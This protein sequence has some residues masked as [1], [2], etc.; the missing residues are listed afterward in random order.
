[1]IIPL[2][3]FRF[4]LYKYR[5]LLL[6]LFSIPLYGRRKPSVCAP[7]ANLSY[8][9]LTFP[10]LHKMP[11]RI[12]WFNFKTT[13]LYLDGNFYKVEVEFVFSCFWTS[14]SPGMVQNET[15]VHVIICCETLYTSYSKCFILFDRNDK[16][17][18]NYI[19]NNQK[20]QFLGEFLR[21]LF[22]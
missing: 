5:L 11:A 1:M 16:H 9:H 19:C 3:I 13:N 12:I 7:A 20:S 17:K 22:N 4:C 14:L 8:F 6:L 18:V 15:W 2:P 21:V 10:K